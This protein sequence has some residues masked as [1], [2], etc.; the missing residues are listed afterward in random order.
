MVDRME[1]TY[2]SEENREHS[3]MRGR[4]HSG[5]EKGQSV[6]WW[7]GGQETLHGME[8]RENSMMGRWEVFWRGGQMSLAGSSIL[9]TDMVGSP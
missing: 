7:G 3:I 4:K 8:G 2:G 5:W 9:S 1:S 6:P